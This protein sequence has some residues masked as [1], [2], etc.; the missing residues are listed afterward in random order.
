MNQNS[1][2]Q[3]NFQNKQI[4]GN[5]QQQTNQPLNHTPFQNQNSQTQ[6]QMQ[7]ENQNNHQTNQ[8]PKQFQFPNQQ[9]QQNNLFSPQKMS[10]QIMT[11]SRNNVPITLSQ[12]LKV[13]RFLERCPII[14]CQPVKTITLVTTITKYEKKNN[15]VL[16]TLNDGTGELIAKDY[17]NF[18]NINNQISNPYEN[19]YVR[20]YASVVMDYNLREIKVKKILP[21]TDSNEI[22]FHFLEALVTHFENT[23]TRKYIN[24]KKFV[25]SNQQNYQNQTQL[26]TNTK[27]IPRE[28]FNSE[29]E[30]ITIEN[31]NNQTINQNN[32]NLQQTSTNPNQNTSQLQFQSQ[33][34]NQ[35]TQ[36]NN[37][38]NNQTTNQ[39]NQ[40]LQQTSLN[41]NQ[42]TSQLQFQSQTQNQNTQQNNQTNNQN[43]QFN[44]NLQQTVLN[45]NQNTSQLQYQ[46]QSQNQNIQQTNQPLNHTPLQNQNSQTQIQMQME[47]QNNQQNFNLQN[48]Q[49][50]ITS[51]ISSQGITRTRYDQLKNMILP[52]IQQDDSDEG[53]G[54]Q[55]IQFKLQNQATANEILEALNKMGS[56]NLIFPSQSA[57]DHWKTY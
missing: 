46:N 2:L 31:Q 26:R 25:I 6:I 39:F 10:N 27:L 13:T 36:Q 1:S 7:M 14:D 42:N 20:I 53:V 44:Q 5:I 45:P 52:I 18:R 33:L 37:H 56:E 24:E 9:F 22:T 19:Q 38:L 23:V 11:H 55:K 4:N 34:H 48:S 8:T 29:N 47:N 40:N 41:P 54:I 51:L 35:N 28:L 30:N 17:L 32:Q 15:H 43:N 16:L 12:I 57:N 49:Y 3:F 50:G 21:I